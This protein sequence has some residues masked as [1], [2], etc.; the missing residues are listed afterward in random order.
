MKHFLEAVDQDGDSTMF[1][2]WF[3]G[4]STEEKAVRLLEPL[5]HGSDYTHLIQPFEKL[6]QDAKVR[7]SIKPC[8]TALR[9]AK[10]FIETP[11]ENCQAN[12]DVHDT[13]SKPRCVPPLVLYII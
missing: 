8:I 1:N 13:R 9:P 5:C 2:T 3:K 10:L 6:H 11:E 7:V 12:L 4:L